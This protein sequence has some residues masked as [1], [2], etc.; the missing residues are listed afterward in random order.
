MLTRFYATQSLSGDP[1]MTLCSAP[2][3][4][5]DAFLAELTRELPAATIAVRFGDPRMLSIDA[6]CAWDAQQII[7][8]HFSDAEI[9]GPRAAAS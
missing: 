6:A 4:E 3:A 8:R 9:L 7:R 2:Q 1:L 5:Q